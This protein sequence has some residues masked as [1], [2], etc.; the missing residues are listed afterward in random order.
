MHSYAGAQTHA[1][2]HVG[3]EAG[4]IIRGKRYIFLSGPSFFHLTISVFLTC[5]T[6]MT[7]I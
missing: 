2:A 6:P 1:R 4:R 7:I 5:I 3:C